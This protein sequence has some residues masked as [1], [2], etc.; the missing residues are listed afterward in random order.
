MAI[1]FIWQIRRNAL[2]GCRPTL[3]FANYSGGG[4]FG[5]SDW[6]TLVAKSASGTPFGQDLIFA[7]TIIASSSFRFVLVVSK[8][9]LDVLVKLKLSIL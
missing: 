2:V 6:M 9:L 7:L 1:T 3:Q 4:N 8:F 5:Y